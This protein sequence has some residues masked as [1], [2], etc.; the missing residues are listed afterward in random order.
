[1]KRTQLNQIINIVRHTGDRV[2]IMD[3][4]SDEIMVLM[5]FKEYKTLLNSSDSDFFSSSF[6]EDDIGALPSFEQKKYSNNSK[7]ISK[8]VS[9]NN[10]SQK[11]ETLPE[12]DFE[13]PS[14]FQEKNNFLSEE[15]LSDISEED[16]EEKFYLEPVEF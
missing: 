4:E 3:A 14:W 6:F 13:E 5:P 8:K 10:L 1:M 2:V 9:L 12:I 11:K 16:E 7:N 15:S